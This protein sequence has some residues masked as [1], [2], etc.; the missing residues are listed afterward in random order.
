MEINDRFDIP[1]FSEMLQ[2]NY[3]TG[4]Y[5]RVIQQGS[6]GLGDE[7]TL[8]NRTNDKWSL[9]EIMKVI[10]TKSLDEETLTSVLT[11]PLVPSWR[12]L[13]MKRLLTGVVEDWSPRLHG[14]KG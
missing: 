3:R 8:I 14:R 12:K 6:V 2:I 13:F 7:I 4:W 10:F 5:F 9:Q 11:L 1:Y